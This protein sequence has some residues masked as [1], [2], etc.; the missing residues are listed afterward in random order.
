MGM[1]IIRD[2]TY[3]DNVIQNELAMLTQNQLLLIRFNTAYGDRKY[4]EQF[5]D[6]LKNF[7]AKYDPK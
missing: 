2:F 1:E 3:I 4:I 7:L 5:V 6:Y